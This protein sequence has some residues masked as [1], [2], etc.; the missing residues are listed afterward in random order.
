M[1]GRLTSAL[2]LL[3]LVACAPARQE[4]PQAVAP[5]PKANP[6][7]VADAGPGVIRVTGPIPDQ[8]ALAPLH[9]AAAKRARALGAATMEWTGGVAKPVTDGYAADMVYET[10]AGG[11]TIGFGGDAKTSGRPE[12]GGPVPVENWLAYCDEAG[13]SREGEA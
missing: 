8:D 2:A 4:G 5:A 1:T 10:A 9:C 7:R 3:A 11:A 12:D 6:V 13:I